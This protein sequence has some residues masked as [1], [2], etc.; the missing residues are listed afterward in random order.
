MTV[1]V[2]TEVVDGI[3]FAFLENASNSEG[4]LF[5]SSLPQNFAAI[6]KLYEKWKEYVVEAAILLL[7]DAN[8][9]AEEEVRRVAVMG[10]RLH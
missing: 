4:K 7:A 1:L 6:P 3:V 5:L 9:M 2:K 10:G 8:G